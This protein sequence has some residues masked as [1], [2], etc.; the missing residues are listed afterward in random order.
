[1]AEDTVD[2]AATL[3]QLDER[4]SVTKE[5]HIH[6]FHKNPRE[7]GTFA[8]YGADAPA[9][10]DLIRGSKAY[11]ELVHPEMSTLAGEVIWAVRHE[12]ARRVEDF[13]SRRTRALILGA[14]ASIEMAPKVAEL[15]AQ[16]LG[17]DESW[18]NQQISTYKNLA[19]G[20]LLI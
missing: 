8:I 9:L 1:M 5:L 19:K 3:A 2:H 18:K 4:P 15:M 14:R 16:E 13:L 20:Y 7:F 12:M 6:G 17:R 11:N 10:Q